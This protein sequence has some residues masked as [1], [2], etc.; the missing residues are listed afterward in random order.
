MSPTFFFFFLSFFLSIFFFQLFDFITYTH[1]DLT[2]NFYNTTCPEAEQ[3]VQNITWKRVGDGPALAA[4]LL[5]LHYH[6]CFVRGC[7]GSLLLDLDT[8][9]N[10]NTP[11]KESPINFFLSGFEII[12]EIKNKLEDVCPEIVSCAD[13]LALVARDAVSHQFGRPLW[14]VFTG[15][16]DGRK[17]SAL[18][19][20]R[21]LPSPFSNFKTLEQLFGVNGL[22]VHDLVVLSGAHTIGEAPC[23]AFQLR[24]ENP[25]D[26]TLNASYAE[27][28]KGICRQGDANVSL[29]P[30]ATTTSKNQFDAHYFTAL[31]LKMGLMESDAALLTDDRGRRVI[32]ELLDKDKFLEEFGKS[33]QRMGDIRVLTG[34]RGEIRR[35]CRKVNQAG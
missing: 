12:D 30:A 33:M 5:R 11:E 7:E 20:S 17:S 21:D 8:N 16:R 2:I 23:S 27:I 18:E 25:I 14:E 28:L 13:I 32:D 29:D 34:T 35:N 24:L 15:R 1:A 10:I 22:S 3:V 9:N 26:P 6:D 19:A 31:K 4:K